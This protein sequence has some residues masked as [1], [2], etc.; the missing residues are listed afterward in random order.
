MLTYRKYS[1]WYA[2]FL[3]KTLAEKCNERERYIIHCQLQMQLRIALQQLRINLK[4]I[5]HKLLFPSPL[6]KII[7]AF[8]E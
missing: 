7:K 2:I 8:W 1:A 4:R 5:R 3:T 6:R